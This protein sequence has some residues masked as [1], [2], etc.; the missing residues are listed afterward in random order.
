MGEGWGGA[1][2]QIPKN[3]CLCLVWKEVYYQHYE[4]A[5]FAEGDPQLVIPYDKLKGILKGK[6][7]PLPNETAVP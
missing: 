3:V 5:S 4:I 2:I 6:Y 1:G 7:L